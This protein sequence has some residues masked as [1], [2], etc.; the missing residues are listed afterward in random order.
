MQTVVDGRIKLEGAVL[1][2]GM[3]DGVHIGHRV[4]LQRAKALARQ[5]GVPMVACTFSNHPM[6]LIAPEK[7]PPMLTTFD[8]RATLLEEQG[9]DLLY[10]MPFDSHMRDMLPEEYIGE[11]VRRFHPTDLVCGYN[12]SFGKK[13]EGSPML[14]E[15]IGD[16]LDFH[17]EIVPKIMFDGHDISS[18]AIRGTLMRGNVA[19]ARALLERPYARGAKV[20]AGGSHLMFLATGKQKVAAGNYR[21]LWQQDGHTYPAMLEVE[22]DE[23]KGVLKLPKGFAISSEGSVQFISR[24]D[25]RT[26]NKG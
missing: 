26:S 19:H 7:C 20:E 1:A 22:Q 16:A 24:A 9:V 12:H 4:L 3:F 25:G 6:M 17:T 21:I 11:L 5:R 10:A 8:E 2:L 18:T 23:N 15:A 13:G 14:L